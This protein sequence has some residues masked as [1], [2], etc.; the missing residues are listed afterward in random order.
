MSDTPAPLGR[1]GWVDITVPDAPRL[2]DFYSQVA[3]WTPHPLG[4]GEYDDYLMT[5]VDGTP[6]AGVCHARGVNAAL[7][8]QWI[9]YIMVTALDDKLG[10]VEAL[11]GKIIKPITSMGASGRYAIIEDPAG[12]VCALFEASVAT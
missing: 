11:G 6:Q 7:P 8:P 4:M 5:A 3:G 2:R 1:I 10:D 9:V 12:A